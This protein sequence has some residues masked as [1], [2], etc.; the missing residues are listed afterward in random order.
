VN[1]VDWMNKTSKQ[2]AENAYKF[3]DAMLAEREK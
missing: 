3:A 2:V 1:G